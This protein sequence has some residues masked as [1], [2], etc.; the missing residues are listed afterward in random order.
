METAQF[1]SAQSAFIPLTVFYI[2]LL[3]RQINTGLKSSG[4]QDEGRR[5][6]IR[7]MI[8]TLLLWAAFIS[9]WSLT[10]TMGDF[11]IFPFNLMPV[12]V[13][14]II[15][16][17]VFISSPVLRQ[18]LANIPPA[19]LVQLQSFRFFVEVLLWMLFTKNLV[20]VQMTF[21]GQNFDILAGLTAPV[22]AILAHRGKISRPGLM[23]WNVLCLGLLLNIVI[24][25]IV[26][27]PSPWRVFMNEPAN[28]IVAE[29]PVSWLPGLLVPLASYLHVMSVTQQLLGKRKKATARE[30]SV[31]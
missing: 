7:R 2:F 18:A 25:A 10:G 15:V 24:T 4:L 16:L 28:Y 20:P 6:F 9:A 13:I 31:A 14:P 19:N 11:S 23:T 27:T 21:E 26:S 17:V 3:L 8:I 12:I 30:T 5:R 1:L 22:V 29:F